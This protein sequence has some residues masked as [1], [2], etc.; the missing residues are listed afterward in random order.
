MHGGVGSPRAPLFGFLRDVFA[1]GFEQSEVSGW[2][3]IGFIEGPHGDVLSGPFADARKFAEIIR[4]VGRSVRREGF[5][6]RL[7]R[8]RAGAR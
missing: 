4:V 1:G 6:H 7:Q 2:K 8:V 5:G 3:R